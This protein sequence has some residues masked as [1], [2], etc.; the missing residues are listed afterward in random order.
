[1]V[2][3]AERHFFYKEWVAI[4][5]YSILYFFNQTI[6]KFVQVFSM[7]LCH[8]GFQK[9]ALHVNVVM[10]MFEEFCVFYISL[11]TVNHLQ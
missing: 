5:S 6:L 11:F 2:L 9:I 4:A 8:N 3:L 7:R 1:M 10:H